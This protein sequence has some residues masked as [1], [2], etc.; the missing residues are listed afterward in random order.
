MGDKGPEICP[1]LITWALCGSLVAVGVAIGEAWRSVAIRLRCRERGSDLADD[2]ILSVHPCKQ[3]TLFQQGTSLHV[4][5]CI[6]EI[7][8]SREAVELLSFSNN[9]TM[10]GLLHSCQILS[11]DCQFIII[12]NKIYSG[13]YQGKDIQGT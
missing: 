1:G 6:Q 8:S 12:A 3:S 7:R 13:E 4:I 9:M 11:L 10:H 5:I 2:I